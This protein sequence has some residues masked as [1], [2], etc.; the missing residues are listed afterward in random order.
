MNCMKSFSGVLFSRAPFLLMTAVLTAGS[1]WVGASDWPS[2]R[3]PNDDGTSLETIRTNWTEQAPAV[4]W[5]VPLDPALSSFAIQGKRAFTQVR[6]TRRNEQIEV[7]IGIDAETGRE[8]WATPLDLALYDGGVGPDDGPRSTPAVDGDRVFVI[9]SYLWLACLD[10]ANGAVI[11]SQDLKQIYNARNIPWQSAASPLVEGDLVILNSNAQGTE[12]LMAVH[13]DTGELVWRR[14]NDHLTHA[15]PVRATIGGVRQ[16]VFLAQSGLVSILPA[17]GTVLWRYPL[18]YNGISVAASP[19][20][21]DNLVYISRAYAGSLSSP[22]AGAVVIKVNESAGKFTASQLWST[23]NR[24][25]N[26]WATPVA[27]NGHLFG[28]YGQSDVKLKCIEFATGVE[29]WSQDGFG[30]G[31][32]VAVNG[33]ILALSDQGELVLVEP[34]PT[35]YTPIDRFRPLNG[36]CWNVPAI[37]NGRLYVRSTLEAV[38][39]DVAAAPKFVPRLRLLSPFVSPDGASR[40]SLGTE[41]GSALDES[42]LAKIQLSTTVDLGLGP[43][44][45]TPVTNRPTLANGFLLFDPLPAAPRQFFRALEL[46]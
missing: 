34:T 13:K 19:V 7:A 37:S 44:G 26:H 25:M 9:T 38:C 23:P 43:D 12:S 20:I 1:F 33:K 30:Y 39:L 17:D 46:P 28:I 36:K 29:K 5:R 31:S 32:V 42:R 40:I 27:L 24:L 18:F 2:Y 8:L 16:T 22:Q 6:R 41:D 11:W 15:T 4:V 45:W 10:A 21:S 3:G 14:H 35:A